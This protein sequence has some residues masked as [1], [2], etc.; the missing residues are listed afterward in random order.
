MKFSWEESPT[1]E[2]YVGSKISKIED[3]RYNDRVKITFTDDSVLIFFVGDCG[4]LAICK[5]EELAI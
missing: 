4:Q 2:S 3:D 1:L 5:S